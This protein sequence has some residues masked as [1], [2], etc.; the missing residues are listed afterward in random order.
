M[1]A[2]G[3]E[4]PEVPAAGSSSAPSVVGLLPPPPPWRRKA[5]KRPILSDSRAGLGLLTIQ[6]SHTPV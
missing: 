5:S 3:V 6:R 1:Q 2:G 4:V